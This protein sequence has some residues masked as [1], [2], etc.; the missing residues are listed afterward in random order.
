MSATPTI[1]EIIGN[2]S[3]ANIAILGLNDHQGNGMGCAKI[4]ADPATS[5]YLAVYG[6][7]NTQIGIATSTNLKDWTFR[8]QIDS[9][10]TQPYI[11]ALPD[12][13][14]LVSSEFNNGGGGHVRLVWFKN[15]QDLLSG[16]GSSTTI[17]I[18]RTLSNCNEGTPNLYSVSLNPDIMHSVISV[19]QHYHWNCDRDREAMGVLRNFA[20]WTTAPQSGVNT[21]VMNGAIAIGAAINGNI[22]ARDYF[23][24][25]NHRYN[26]IEAQY[27]KGDF[28]TWNFYLY[29]WLFGTAEEIEMV[30]A[31]G[32]LGSIG[33]P[34]VSHLIGP[35]GKPCLVMTGFMFN[36]QVGP[37]L[38]QRSYTPDPTFASSTYRAH[39]NTQIVEDGIFGLNSVMSVQF[40][41][42]VIPP[43]GIWSW[44]TKADMQAHLGRP[45]TGSLSFTDITVLQ[46]R[47]GAVPDGQWGSGTTKALQHA[48]NL[49]TY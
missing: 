32:P 29:D 35:D 16:G 42:N 20:E 36:P 22:G 24:Y 37:A 8:A 18:P 14:F 47:I 10:A 4:I 23:R 1:Q 7:G 21:A 25:D 19:G 27:T 39:H 13:S 12:G 45:V 17:N 43:D 15:R 33:N 2:I 49:G 41:D 28:G 34:R 3:H 30:S 9:S 48:L 11:N 6:Y 38:W 5:G 44:R 40:V 46:N 26:L 31:D